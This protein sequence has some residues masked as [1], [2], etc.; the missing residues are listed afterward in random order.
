MASTRTGR[1]RSRG[2]GASPQSRW[3]SAVRPPRTP[4]P[5]RDELSRRTRRRAR[6]VAPRWR[7]S[8]GDTGSRG[9]RRA[10]SPGSAEAAPGAG[11]RSR[12]A[13]YRRECVPHPRAP[14]PPVGVIVA[15]GSRF[16][17]SACW[18]S[19][20]PPSPCGRR[21]GDGAGGRRVLCCKGAASRSLA[22]TGSIP[23]NRWNMAGICAVYRVD[24]ASPRRRSRAGRAGR[25]R[26]GRGAHRGEARMAQDGQR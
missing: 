16:A 7:R 11:R 4:V 12:S 15:F 20:P 9:R 2:R 3:A 21:P 23:T 24:A 26:R 18:V 25:R 6:T 1:S 17:W 10:P 22:A 19:G 5:R 13:A 8:S 14:E